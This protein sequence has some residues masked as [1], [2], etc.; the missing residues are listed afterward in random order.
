MRQA[1]MTEPGNIEFRDVSVPDVKANEVLL[2]IKQIGICGSDIHVNHGK[3]PFTPYP[4]VQGHEF[5]GIVKETGSDVSSEIQPGMKATALPQSVCGQ[6]RPCLRGDFHICDELKVKGFQAPGCAQDFFI[7]P[8]EMVIPLPDSFTYEQ[9][10][11]IEPT[12]VATHSTQR[13][14]DLSGKNVVV[15]GAGTIGNLVAQVVRSR[16]AKK[17]LITDLSEFR[18]EIARKCGIEETTN[19]NHETLTEASRRVFGE[20]GFDIA[21]EAVGVEAT[22][23]AVVETIQKGGSIVVLGVFEEKPRI[24][25]SI[26]G[27][28]ELSII[29]TL[30]Y[31]HKDYQEAV[32]LIQSGKVKTQP[33]VTKH[34][35]FEEYSQ[36]YRFIDEK[37]D[38]SMKIM[39]DL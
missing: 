30:M 15:L 3:H 13:A 39:I 29:G 20:E 12:S 34:F 8:D 16:G 18:L 4:V 24:D 11:L 5:M 1:I 36:A 32:E 25:M 21:F 9:G 14:G 37:K 33:L 17:I 2:E 31:Q 35:P 6:C 19:V 27:D 38:K 7:A 22:M 26:V 10:A 28:R 23:D